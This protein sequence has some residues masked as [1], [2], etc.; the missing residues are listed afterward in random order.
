MGLIHLGVTEKSGVITV[1]WQLYNIF[2]LNNGWNP[3]DPAIMLFSVTPK[4]IYPRKV[5]RIKNSV[6]LL[7]LY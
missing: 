5:L 4:L 1:K 7:V 2:C 6:F 3:R